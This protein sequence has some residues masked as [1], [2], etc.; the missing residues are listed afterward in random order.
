VALPFLAAC[1]VFSKKLNT[2]KDCARSEATAERVRAM[3][4]A[5]CCESLPKDRFL[6]ITAG[7]I[8]R[9]AM[10]LVGSTRP[11]C[12]EKGPQ[13][14]RGLEDLLAHSTR[15]AIAFLSERPSPKGEGFG[16]KR[17]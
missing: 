16:R 15:L 14:I 4:T 6:M 5:P 11:R 13:R 2:G 12:R 8:A 3:N 7:R 17:Q 9:S 10:L 1:T